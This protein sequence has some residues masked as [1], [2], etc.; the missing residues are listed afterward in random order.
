L[1]NRYALTYILVSHDLS[2]AGHLSDEVLVMF[3]GEM[4]ERG[5]PNALFH[6]PLHPHTKHLVRAALSISFRD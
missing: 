5:A 1:Q 3:D 2:L 4:V 6:A